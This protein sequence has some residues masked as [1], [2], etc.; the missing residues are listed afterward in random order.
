MVLIRCTAN[1]SCQP[2]PKPKV[3]GQE[4][5]RP[6]EGLASQS[7]LAKSQL[8]LAQPYRSPGLLKASILFF[9]RPNSRLSSS[10]LSPP[11]RTLCSALSC[12]VLP[13]LA[14]PWSLTKIWSFGNG[15][16]LPVNLPFILITACGI[17][18]ISP[19]CTTYCPVLSCPGQHSYW[20]FECQG[21]DPPPVPSPGPTG[22][23]RLLPACMTSDPAFVHSSQS[24][25]RSFCFCFLPLPPS[26]NGVKTVRRT[27]RQSV[28]RG[29]DMI[30]SMLCL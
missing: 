7:Q 21:Q 8:C 18:S 10:P 25:S 11:N 20:K 2:P 22:D 13:C 27:W 9:P 17:S 5:L 1:L 14:L 6:T 23:T 24:N 16:W 15:T 29:C 30:L 3:V 12:P 26:R 19:Y 28:P 4:R